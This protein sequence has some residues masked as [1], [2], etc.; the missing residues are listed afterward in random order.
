MRPLAL[1]LSL[2]LLLSS[3]L[4][5]AAGAHV[6]GEAELEVAIDAS[7]LVIRLQSPL[8]SLVG[9]EHAPRNERERALLQKAADTLRDGTSLFG[10]PTEAGCSLQDA[11]VELPGAAADHASA[12]GHRSAAAQWTF[13]CK[14]HERLHRIELRL[15]QPFPRLKTLHVQ[16]VGPA[17]QG[18]A[19]LGPARTTLQF[20][21]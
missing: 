16:W 13:A 8:D 6:H 4:A 2:L 18:G 14:Q 9:F 17:G 11:N 7:Q 5:Q 10:L 12:D 3:P 20:G 15:F 19:K 21:R 1:T